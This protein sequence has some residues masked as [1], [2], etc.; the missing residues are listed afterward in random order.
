MG[1]EISDEEK[2]FVEKIFGEFGQKVNFDSS[3]IDKGYMGNIWRISE[4]LCLKVNKT[5]S[6]FHVPSEF[7]SNENLC[8]PLKIFISPSGKYTGFVQ[9]FLNKSSIQYLIKENIKLPTNQVSEI[10]FDILNGLTTIHKSGYVHRDFYPGNIMLTERK[11][12]VTA[13]IIDFDEMKKVSTNTKACFQYNGYQAPEI[14]FDNDIYDEKS[15]MFSFGIIFWELVIGKCPF[16]GYDFF[17]KVIEDSWNK[18]LSNKDF[19]NNKVKKALETLP[20]HINSIENV[21]D[22]CLDLINSLLAFNRDD[23]ITAKDA[24][25]HPFFKNIHK[26]DVKNIQL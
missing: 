10:L 22:E 16:G 18:Y 5:S 24:L 12:K 3:L 15:E 9:E 11:H 25:K 14:V 4:H 8:V 13:V 19:Y 7:K 26:T 1:I 21:S 17:G 23:R 20:N 2:E 6:S